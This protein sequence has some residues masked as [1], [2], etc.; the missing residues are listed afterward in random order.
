MALRGGVSIMP[1]PPPKTNY[2]FQEFLEVSHGICEKEAKMLNMDAF[3]RRIL[4]EEE[5]P[6]C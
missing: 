3:Q 4:V 5:C 2:Y 1:S 6:S